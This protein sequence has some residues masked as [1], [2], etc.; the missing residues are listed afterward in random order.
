MN[1]L[2]YEV[3]KVR[4]KIVLWVSASYTVVLMY[5]RKICLYENEHFS[6]AAMY[7]VPLLINDMGNRP[8]GAVRFLRAT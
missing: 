3:Q 4:I 8:Q 1:S 5:K 2:S 7:T 6:I